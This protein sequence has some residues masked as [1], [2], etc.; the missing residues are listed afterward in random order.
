MAKPICIT[1]FYAD[2]CGYCKDFHPIWESMKDETLEN[3]QF[4]DYESSK[5][6]NLKKEKKTINGNEI[7]GFPTLKIDILGT[8]YRYPKER[9][10]EAIYTYIRDVLKSKLARRKNK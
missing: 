10:P 6:S 1:L 7:N 5:L 4:V 3:I 8:E 9:S 2:W